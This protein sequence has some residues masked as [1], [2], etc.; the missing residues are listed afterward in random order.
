MGYLDD[1]YQGDREIVAAQGL[2]VND[3]ALIESLK[4]LG[5]FVVFSVS[6]V[7]GRQTDAFMGNATELV[8]AFKTRKDIPENILK[9][10]EDEDQDP[11]HY[12]VL[13]SPPEGDPNAGWDDVPQGGIVATYEPGEDTSD[14]I[15]F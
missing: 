10:A 11:E 7:F 5:L 8:G 1:L 3:T 4:A 12:W 6:A 15:P 9:A 13:C 2:L 14:E